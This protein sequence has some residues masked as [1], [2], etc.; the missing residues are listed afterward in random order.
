MI[1]LSFIH[2]FWNIKNKGMHK[3]YYEEEKSF[4]NLAVIEIGTNSTKLLIAQM[5]NGTINE[6]IQKKSV[7]N[8]L[9][10]RMY[11]GNIISEEAMEEGLKIIGEFLE[12]IRI[13]NAELIGIISTSV[14]R[15]AI[16]SNLFIEEVK[17]FYGYTI[18]VISGEKEALFAYK[19]CCSHVKNG[20]EKFA[21]ID[22]GG[23]ST[24]IITGTSDGIDYKSS[25]NVGAVRMTEM[26]VK[27]DPISASSIDDISK[28][29]K[30]KINTISMLFN[31]K[32]HLLGTGGTIKT[33]ATMYLG[34]D[35]QNESEINGLIL[36]CE[37]VKEIFLSM[38]SKDIYARKKIIGLNPKRA[39]VISSGLIILLTLMDTFETDVITVSSRGVIE[40]FIE[41]YRN[42]ITV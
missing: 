15:D 32:L 31:G 14:L 24:E 25:I 1:I 34:I 19:A 4:M 39:D 38:V 30:Q 36:S 22:I 41:N 7:V 3:K 20:S 5:L 21:V 33:A 16:N 40:G 27:S 18:D 8:R 28:Y 29:I 11:E 35:Y 6:V 37:T 42:T 17:K 10:K 2:G 9:S 23:G 26:F 13:H 12:V